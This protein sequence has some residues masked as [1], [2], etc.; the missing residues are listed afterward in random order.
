MERIT[1]L[2]KSRD[3]TVET[4]PL[5]GDVFGAFIA[6]KLKNA[7]Y[8]L[9]K[10][11]KGCYG[12]CGYEFTPAMVLTIFE[13]M[14]KENIK[15]DFNIG[16][17]DDVNY[18]ALDMPTEQYDIFP[19]GTKECVFWGMG[20]DGT[21]G[22]NR[23]AL[24]I[25]AGE[26]DMYAQGYFNFDAKKTGGTTV[27]HLRFSKEPINAPFQ[28]TNESASY[29][30]VHKSSY[31]QLYPKPI[32]D[33]LKKN[34]IF[35]LNAEFK[36]LEEFDSFTPAV[37]KKTLAKQNASVYMV[38][39]VNLAQEIGLGRRINNIMQTVFFNLT[40]IT[41]DIDH[42]ISLLKEAIVKTYS[43]YGDEVV[44][45]NIESVDKA[46]SCVTK[47]EIPKEWTD[48]EDE[49][50]IKIED[51]SDAVND[52]ILPSLR[53]EGPSIPVSKL[54]DFESGKW[55]T[56]TA[57]YEKRRLAV[58]VPTWDCNNCIEC[59]LC[60]LSC[61]HA[62]IRPVV[63]D[64]DQE[65]PESF[66]TKGLKGYKGLDMDFR[67]QVYPE[68]CLGCG[69]CTEIC[70][71]DCLS[72]VNNDFSEIENAKL[73]DSAEE[74]TTELCGSDKN[75]RSSQFLKPFLEFSGACAGCAQTPLIKLITQLF[76]TRLQIACAVGCAMVWGNM[77]PPNPYCRDS[78]GRGPVIAT[79]LFEDNAEFGYGLTV[80]GR[81]R[82]NRLI[83]NVQHVIDEKLVSENS[84]VKLKEWLDVRNDLSAVEK[85]A[86]ELCEELEM[87]QS[88]KAK[89]IM[90]ASD[91]FIPKS[92]WIIGGDGWAYDIDFHGLDHVL[93]SGENIN[94]LIMDTEVY[95]NT[96]GQKSKA[97]PRAAVAKFAA[98]GK[99]EGK[100]DV[101]QMFMSYE[102]VFVGSIALDANP[103]HALKVIKEAEAYDGPSVIIAYCPCIAHNIDK[104][105]SQ[106]PDIMNMAVETRYW[107]LFKFDPTLLASGKNP[108]KIEN[109]RKEAPPVD[110]FINRQIRFKQLA[111]I[112]PQHAP[113]VYADLQ[114]DV[115]R[116][117][118]KLIALQ[119]SYDAKK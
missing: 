73:A 69:V 30:A 1:V 31:L 92:Y 111:K 25:I 52:V 38:D 112:D 58:Q 47:L 20:G 85:I 91:L 46:M 26:T 109:V 101:F 83:S 50:A 39:A 107:P 86:D 16:I 65:R 102:N 59:N 17:Y 93:A 51:A 10:L 108:L 72:M 18:R 99:R 34:G 62:A 119:N 106:V 88:E 37:L 11:I 98:G 113:E 82:R 81:F 77:G 87:D 90:L 36:T 49:Q 66:I 80:G 55:P 19:E 103:T 57:K 76:N 60:T 27:S 15:D 56:D 45:L 114:N 118:N 75:V 117:W 23:N 71:K 3:L 40:N 116:R 74:K 100:K 29:L 105:M 43:K 104:G 33:F 84:L 6:K 110:E 8:K 97:T 63:I 13:N 68:D 35:I 64:S 9:P 94:V 48:L 96:G 78:K 44:R 4:Q 22:A 28:I 95:S 24:A 67:I 32:G 2:D 61:P 7:D 115:N 53:W 54:K 89:E 41:G 12:L 14:A 42:A 21:I 5:A 70:P 79:S